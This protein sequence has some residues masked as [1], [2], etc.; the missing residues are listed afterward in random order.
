VTPELEAALWQ[1]LKRARVVADRFPVLVMANKALWDLRAAVA[2]VDAAMA[3]PAEYSLPQCIC[4]DWAG[5]RFDLDEAGRPAKR[6]A[7]PEA[8]VPLGKITRTVSPPTPDRAT[9]AP[10]TC[11]LLHGSSTCPECGSGL[12]YQR[13]KGAVLFC[14][15]Q[16]CPCY[17]PPVG[18]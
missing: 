7:G 9:A 11:I 5:P 18:R 8:A 14:L 1:L 3:T 16:L 6:A 13:G 2:A 10:A 17:A 12:Y 4:D 15:S